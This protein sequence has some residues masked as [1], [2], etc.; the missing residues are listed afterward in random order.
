MFLQV[1]ISRLKLTCLTL[2][3]LV[4]VICVRGGSLSWPGRGCCSHFT[5]LIRFLASAY[6]N[7]RSSE[8]R[9][10]YSRHTMST[11]V[12]STSAIVRILAWAMFHPTQIRPSEGT[13]QGLAY[14]LARTHS[15]TCDGND[16]NLPV[17]CNVT[18][19]WP[20]AVKLF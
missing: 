1:Q 17:K 7:I 14:A 15:G 4:T 19:T 5:A 16:V 20:Q 8:L 12:V 11:R 3:P 2:L 6:T 18:A 10:N 13:G 9:Y